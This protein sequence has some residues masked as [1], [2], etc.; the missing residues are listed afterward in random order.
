M[1]KKA[2]AHREKGHKGESLAGEKKKEET[3]LA[4]KK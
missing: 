4:P 2:K 1:K 3:D